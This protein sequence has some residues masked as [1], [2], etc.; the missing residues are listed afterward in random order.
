MSL[1]YPMFKK[2]LLLLCAVLLLIQIFR[3]ARNIAAIVSQSKDIS[4]VVAVPQPVE[5]ILAKACYDCHSNSSHYPWY[6]NIQPV[7]WWIAH[8]IEEGKEE[9]NFSDFADYSLKR[10]VHKFEEI[11]DEVQ[12]GKMPLNSYTWTHSEARLNPEE[13]RLLCN[14]A[15]TNAAELGKKIPKE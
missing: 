9:L 1:L 11:A 13:V 6:Y 7:A 4:T 8:H 5:A 15:N 12:E 3:P 14:W 2:I 10:Q